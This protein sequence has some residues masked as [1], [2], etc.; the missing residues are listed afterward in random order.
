[1]T[2]LSDK[3]ASRRRTFRLVLIL[4]ILGILSY[5]WI[6]IRSSLIPVAEP[7]FV[8]AHGIVG[9]IVG[10]PYAFV[11]YMRSRDSFLAQITA[12]EN[13]TEELE[14][15]IALLQ[16]DLAIAQEQADI[17]KLEGEK[18]RASIFMY[19]LAEDITKLYSTIL[20][21][22]G[23]KDG[24][25]DGSI[26]YVRGREAVC[27]I[28]ELHSSTSLCKLFSAAGNQIEGVAL[29][30]KENIP[31]TGD[32]GGNYLALLPKGAD[33]SIGETVMYKSDQ[34]MKLGTIADIKN[35]P[36]D[37]FVRVYVRGAYNPLTSS[38]FYTD[39]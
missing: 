20:L 10:V 32:G 18:P 30:T 15:Q 12:L 8:T 1:M 28:E 16:N 36:Q 11:N 21:S 31:L 37:I 35:D 38:I 29:S 33:F 5:G 17:I 7:M 19:P 34:T 6:R 23:F 13:H 14:N 2:Y 25:Q 4:A 3:T 22:K 24:V 39:K 27:V 26:V 9:K